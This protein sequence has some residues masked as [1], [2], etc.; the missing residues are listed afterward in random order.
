MD[1]CRRSKKQENRMMIP[2]EYVYLFEYCSKCTVVRK[3]T[4]QIS[5]YSVSEVITKLYTI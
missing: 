5:S 4:F 3:D 2:Y 1:T